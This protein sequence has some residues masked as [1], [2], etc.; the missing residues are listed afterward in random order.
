MTGFKSLTALALFAGA[1][2][3]IWPQPVSYEHGS[4]VV[5]IS[6]DISMTFSGPTNN[7]EK[8]TDKVNQAWDRTKTILLSDSLVPWKFHKRGDNYEP[9]DT[10]GPKLKNIVIKQTTPETSAPAEYGTDES[11]NLTIP[12]AGDSAY[13]TAPTSFGVLHA[14]NTL[15]QLF[16]ASKKHSSN[17]VYSPLAPVKVLDKP[18]FQHRGLN[19]DVAR[20]WYPKEDILRT[21]DALAWNKMNRLHLHVTDS[22]SWPLEIP[23]LP[24]LAPCGAYAEG[25]TYT[26]EDLAEILDFAEKRGVQVI[27]EIDMPGHTSAI[28]EAY[29]ELIA[30]WN[31]QPNWDRYAAQPPSGSLKLNNEAVRKFLTTLFG[32]LLPRLRDHTRYFHTGG[33]EVNK[34]VY[35]F[36]EGIASNATEVLTPALQKFVD[37]VHSE[38]RNGKMSPV[39]WEEMLIDWKLTLPKDVIVQTWIS[40]ASTKTA[41]EKGHRVIAGNYNF[42]YLDCGNGQWL[43]FGPN[44]YKQF[45]PFNDYCSPKKN[46]RLMYSFDPVA[47]LTSEQAALVLGGEVHAWSEQI[48]GVSLDSVVWPRASA[49]GEVLWSGRTDAQGVNR[50]FADASP[51]LAEF[52]ERLVL[53][54]VGA[55]PI[56]QLW[57]HQNEGDCALN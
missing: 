10:N 30:G 29:P 25:L 45:Y 33:D 49:A 24:D 54:G 22:Q 32:D 11:Y 41:V 35:L 14:L 55:S 40:D 38:V 1:A 57:C 50:T 28:A 19:L 42:W 21:I 16:Y 56:M 5:W 34:N 27:I 2:N 52:R 20:Q 39:V 36:D 31:I 3:A 4:T 46:W 8:A 43:D 12:D 44:V 9:A 7:S 23:A 51:R 47:G 37:H 6:D 13:I 15:T 53:R 48:D 26:P 17:G 18:K